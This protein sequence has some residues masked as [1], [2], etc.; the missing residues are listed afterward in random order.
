VVVERIVGKEVGTHEP[1]T[2]RL[3]G[4]DGIA[5]FILGDTY[6]VDEKAVGTLFPIVGMRM[7]GVGNSSAPEQGTIPTRSIPVRLVRYLPTRRR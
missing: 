1:L 6:P 7:I 2:H 3:A 5:I 4:D